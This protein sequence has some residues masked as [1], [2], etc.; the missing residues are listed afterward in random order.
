MVDLE[1]AQCWIHTSNEWLE[2]MKDGPVL[3]GEP[4]RPRDQDSMVQEA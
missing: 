1:T 3:A 4:L 2:I